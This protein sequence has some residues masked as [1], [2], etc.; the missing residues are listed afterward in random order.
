[1]L[2]VTVKNKTT[3][4]KYIDMLEL[5]DLNNI[6]KT[7]LMTSYNVLNQSLSN[8]QTKQKILK[9]IVSNNPKLSKLTKKAFDK[10]VSNGFLSKHPTGKST[11]YNLTLKGL[12]AGNKLL[13]DN[14]PDGISI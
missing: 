6:Q 4:A 1:M 8:H 3:I 5:G 9:S 13:N 11:T 14:F 2:S 12:K 10:L 7:V